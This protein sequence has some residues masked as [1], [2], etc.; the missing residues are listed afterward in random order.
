M[1]NSSFPSLLFK[2]KG[3]EKD[4]DKILEV[5]SEYVNLTPDVKYRKNPLSWL[6]GK[7]W[8][9]IEKTEYSPTHDKPFGKTNQI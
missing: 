8:N 4:I 5:V 7:C 2:F 1:T 9:D 3:L 6:N